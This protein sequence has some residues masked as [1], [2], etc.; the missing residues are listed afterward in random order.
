M[1]VRSPHTVVK[2]S[3][4]DG[5]LKM[6]PNNACS[7]YFLPSRVGSSSIAW[8]ISHFLWLVNALHI[9]SGNG[10][11]GLYKS[12]HTGCV[13]QASR[14]PVQAH[15]KPGSML[16]LKHGHALLLLAGPLRPSHLCLAP[17]RR[18]CMNS[19]VTVVTDELCYGARHSLRAPR[20]YNDGRREGWQW[21]GRLGVDIIIINRESRSSTAKWLV[22]AWSKVLSRVKANRASER[23]NERP[24]KHRLPSQAKPPASVR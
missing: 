23:A 8:Y 16:N 15:L 9:G 19:S 21:L 6:R 3:R 2:C 11:R 13:I 14:S 5:K 12:P 18:A 4:S 20:S 24:T 22:R 10:C 17:P 7:H 1:A